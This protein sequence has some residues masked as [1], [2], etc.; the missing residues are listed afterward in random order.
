[1]LLLN[2]PCHSSK[3]RQRDDKQHASFPH[4]FY[5]GEN[6]GKTHT[7]VDCLIQKLS[8]NAIERAVDTGR[9]RLQH[10]RLSLPHQQTLDTLQSISQCCTRQALASRSAATTSAWQDAGSRRSAHE[11]PRQRM[12]LHFGAQ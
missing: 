6:I 5:S 7:Y 4:G 1:M 8:T 3:A 11:R 10:A 12:H 2:M 9:H